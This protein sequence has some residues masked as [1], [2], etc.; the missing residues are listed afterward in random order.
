MKKVKP[1]EV[2]WRDCF[3]SDTAWKFASEPPD[4]AII[5]HSIGWPIKNYKKG[6]LV[7][8][9]TWFKNGGD[10]VVYGQVTYI[11]EEMVISTRKLK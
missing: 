10:E 9:E 1:I 11:P 4:K 8:A 7:L 6:Y 2:T 5:C 3:V